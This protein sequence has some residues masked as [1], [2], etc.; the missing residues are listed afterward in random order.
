MPGHIN[1]IAERAVWIGIH[2]YQRLVI[3]LPAATVE[4]EK[5]DLGPAL[6]AIERLRDRHLGALNRGEGAIA[7][8]NNQGVVDIAMRL[9]DDPGIRAEISAV[10]RLRRRNALVH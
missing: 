1:T 5:G 7:E 9:E 2:G 6:P 10:R 3:E 8:N 4:V